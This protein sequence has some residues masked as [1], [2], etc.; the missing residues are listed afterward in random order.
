MDCYCK[1]ESMVDLCKFLEVQCNDREL[2]MKVRCSPPEIWCV[3]W[4]LFAV[5]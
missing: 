2:A 3:C 4:V 1:E 5:S